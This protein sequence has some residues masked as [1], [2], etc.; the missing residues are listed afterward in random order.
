MEHV[1]QEV[2]GLDQRCRRQR[3]QVFPVH[4]AAHRKNR[5]NRAKPIEDRA[6]AHVAG[7]DDQV[8]SAQ[9]IERLRPQQAVGIGD[10]ADDE[11]AHRFKTPPAA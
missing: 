2:L 6:L 4:I 3:R 9:R 11:L 8:R 10:D 7:V 1:Q 5:R